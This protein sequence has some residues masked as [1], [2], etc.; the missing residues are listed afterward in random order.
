MQA[1][2]DGQILAW[3]QAGLLSIASQPVRLFFCS[4]NPVPPSWNN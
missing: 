4:V 3:Q 2:N 1:T